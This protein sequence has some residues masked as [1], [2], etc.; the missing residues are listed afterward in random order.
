MN[1]QT[2]GK[3]LRIMAD[4]TGFYRYCP[5]CDETYTIEKPVRQEVAA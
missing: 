4:A 3:E 2:C 5:R 1:C